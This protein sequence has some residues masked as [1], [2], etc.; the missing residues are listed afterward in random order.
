[1]HTC[2]KHSSLYTCLN[3]Y[4]GAQTAAVRECMRTQRDA[5]RAPAKRLRNDVFLYQIF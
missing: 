4:T 2:D 3:H 1:M 5:V